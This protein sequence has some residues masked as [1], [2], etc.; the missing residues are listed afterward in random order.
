MN[1]QSHAIKPL[2]TCP[3]DSVTISGKYEVPE[4]L[5]G[6]SKQFIDQWGYKW[7]K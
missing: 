6:T 1:L 2:L 3:R 7:K 5:I 4:G